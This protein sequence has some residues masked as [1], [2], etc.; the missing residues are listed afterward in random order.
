[1]DAF[2][3]VCVCTQRVRRCWDSGKI[4]L[5]TSEEQTQETSECVAIFW[6]PLH[7]RNRVAPVCKLCPFRFLATLISEYLLMYSN[8]KFTGPG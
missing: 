2:V 6:V 8:Y 3:F 1:M 7:F 5:Q 4:V